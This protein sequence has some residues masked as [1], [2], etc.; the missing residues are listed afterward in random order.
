MLLL[1]LAL[2]A[3]QESAL[4]TLGG[5]NSLLACGEQARATI[6]AALSVRS[7]KPR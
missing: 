1:D 7:P 6:I 4:A 3:G 5:K 2:L